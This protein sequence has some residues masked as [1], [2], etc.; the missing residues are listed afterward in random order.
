MNKQDSKQQAIVSWGIIGCGDV[1]EVKS[2]PAFNQV[3]GSRLMAV[4][5]RDAA[6]AADYAARHGVGRW[7]D[8]ASAMMDDPDIN[9]VYIATPPAYHAPYAIEALR[10]GLCVYL[11]KPVTLNAAEA[12]ALVAVVQQSGARLTA[13]H[14][15]RALP[16]FLFVKDLLDQQ[17]IGAVRTVHIRTWQPARPALVTH[18]QAPWRL[19]PALSGGGYFHDLAPHQL[20]LMLYFFGMPKWMQGLAL[21]QANISPADDHVTGTILFDN[22]IVLNGSWSFNVSE[23]DQ[24][25]ECLIAGSEG[26]IRFPFFGKAVSWQNNSVS[27]VQTR[28]FEHPPHIH[29]PMIEQVVN[30]FQHKAA[31]PCSIEEAATG[32]RI[33]DAFTAP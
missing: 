17:A 22:D 21:N 18:T 33:M 5:R 11:E 16:M 27:S 26:S 12:E 14:Y 10:R 7:Y 29:Q 30:Y 32:M 15:R 20:D 13:A 2:G 3:P 25:D 19:N 28:Y 9:A 23:R 6:K 1:T 31:N 24:V 4:M 8:D